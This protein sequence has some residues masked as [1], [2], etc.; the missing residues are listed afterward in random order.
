MNKKQ[1]IA[2]WI[3]LGVAILMI[4]IVPIKTEPMFRRNTPTLEYRFIT[5]LGDITDGG[6]VVAGLLFA[7]LVVLTAV[8]AGAIYTLKDKSP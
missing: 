5:N 3:G 7:Q 4:L 1:M 2:L 6:T 8:T